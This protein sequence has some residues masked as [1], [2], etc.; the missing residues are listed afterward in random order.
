MVVNKSTKYSHASPSMYDNSYAKVVNMNFYLSN[1][2][3]Y[4]CHEQTYHIK[5]YIVINNYKYINTSTP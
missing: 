2:T 1:F 5:Y 4:E 3:R